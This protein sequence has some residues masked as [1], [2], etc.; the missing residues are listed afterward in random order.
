MAIPVDRWEQE[1]EEAEAKITEAYPLAHSLSYEEVSK[2]NKEA[3]KGAHDVETEV[4]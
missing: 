4:A 3:V 1:L 2:L